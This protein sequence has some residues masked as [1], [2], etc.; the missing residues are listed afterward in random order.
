MS[1]LNIEPNKATLSDF[2]VTVSIV[3]L[4]I[5]AYSV[6]EMGRSTV[7]FEWVLLSLVTIMLVSRIDISIPRTTSTV[8]LS[9][10]FIFISLLLYGTH[11]SV[12]LAGLDAAVC[13]L[14]LKNR[15]KI[16]WFNAGVMSLSVFVA[17]SAG[18]A[19]FGDLRALVFNMDRLCMAAGMMALVHYILNSGLMSVVTAL[20]HGHSL[21]K[22][23]KNS[24]LWTSISYFA[25]AVTAC[26]VIKLITLISFYAFIISVPIL[27]ITY[28]TYKV[29][30]DRVETSNRHAEQMADLHLRT[31]EAL[32]IA[33]DAKDEVTHDHVRRVQIYA[34]GL[35]RLFG[36]SEP[37]IE[38]LKAGALLHDI[39]KLAV[40]DYILN[41][42]GPLT[43]AEFD[44]MKV[45]TIVGA[46]ILE[47]VGFPYPVVPVVRHH[48]ERWDGR[49]YPDGL[50]GD[51]IPITARIL[52]VSDC[53]DAVREDRQ[54][55]KAMTREEAIAL[56]KDGSGT[57]F[58]PTVISTFLDHLNEF[59]SEIRQ[60]QV[61]PQIT[62]TR[63]R[64]DAGKDAKPDSGPV[65]FER[66]R[67]AHREV[68][69]LYDIAQTIG[70][71]LDLRD[72]FAVFSSR[73]QDIVSYT[74]C[75]LYLVR[76]D[77][78]ELEAAHVSGRHSERFK[79][80]RIPSGAGI[81]GW[82]VANRHPMHNCDPRLDFD[83]IKTELDEK[84][85]TAS[86]VPLMREGNMLGALAL[87]SAEL[88][89][90]TA[91]HLRLMEAVAKLASDAIANAVHHEQTE[92]SA[93]TDL[94]TGLPNARALRYRFEEESDRARR[95]RDVFS[96][97]MMDLDGFKA[98]N[99]RLGHQAGDHLLKEL[100][101]LLL[102]QI[103]SSDF[104]ARYAGDEFVA[105][106]QAGPEEA[107]EA[108][109]RIQRGVD[110]HDFGFGASKLF[111]GVSAGW[112]CFG[113]DGNTLD[114]L[115]LAAD[116]AMYADKSRRKTLIAESRNTNTSDLSQY[117]VM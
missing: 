2:T 59:E 67:S 41:K 115:L 84:Y 108:V 37:E 79:G 88:T 82:V 56:L 49:G 52:M 46:E 89:S 106:L 63:K 24:F 47:R 42:P 58:D 26:L 32:A 9:D 100:S 19:V 40:P 78:T 5:F 75:V 12:V 114:E 83:V 77:S 86:V 11:A 14:H 81:T 23:W 16:I 8:T 60:Q 3:G 20:K 53:F 6:I 4:L 15:R 50:R 111:I 109:Q 69:T 93:L 96:V 90:Y 55:R 31:I 97:V 101:N 107:K 85:N 99:D 117:R 57:F 87:Y 98:V 39:G 7:N 10:T 102:S 36:L 74:T 65:V 68:I 80:R 1:R 95:H 45:H 110:R 71:S 25:G 28:F 104:I 116:R 91:D 22:T 94:L 30:L 38:A 44:K 76:Q 18:S 48:H 17:G 33:I 51:E 103:R 29:Y 27:T 73:L 112:A 64:K 34:K 43:P 13:T 54:Y 62:E 72:T 61:E 113:E 21:I 92:T 66:I 70:T 105:I 35:A